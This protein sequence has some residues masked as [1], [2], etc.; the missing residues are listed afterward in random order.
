MICFTKILIDLFLWIHRVDLSFD[1]DLFISQEEYDFFGVQADMCQQLE[2]PAQ[3]V[4]TN[5]L[6]SRPL[7]K[8]ESLQPVVYVSIRSPTTMDNFVT[9]QLPTLKLTFPSVHRTFLLSSRFEEK[10]K[11]EIVKNRKSLHLCRSLEDAQIEYNLSAMRVGHV[12]SARQRFTQVTAVP[13]LFDDLP[14]IEMKK[15]SVSQVTYSVSYLLEIFPR[16]PEPSSESIRALQSEAMKMDQS[17]QTDPVPT[18]DPSQPM[19]SPISSPE[20]MD[21]YTSPASPAQPYSHCGEHKKWIQSLAQI[22]KRPQTFRTMLQ[23]VHLAQQVD[24]YLTK[25]KAAHPSEKENE[26]ENCPPRQARALKPRVSSQVR[27]HTAVHEQQQQLDLRNVLHE[28]H[29]EGPFVMQQ[30]QPPPFYT[31]PLRQQQPP[32]LPLPLHQPLQQQQQP[33]PLSDAHFPYRTLPVKKFGR[34]FN[35]RR[36]N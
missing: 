14:H 15:N 17:I 33:L 7:A 23:Y 10:V 6:P 21:I 4:D 22:H 18:T 36:L 1:F 19:Y 28:R 34:K 16:V 2:V 11:S 31:M 26:K 8:E 27:A 12:K 24:S 30:Q 29:Y 3:A 35:P 32:L 20:P 5:D 9:N 25:H 13:H